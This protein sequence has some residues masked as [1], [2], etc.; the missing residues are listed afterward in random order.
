MK[1]RTYIG[2]LLLFSDAATM[3]ILAIYFRFISKNW[4][5]FQLFSLGLNIFSAFSLFAI[6]E[7]PKFLH[8]KQQYAKAKRSLKF[9]ARFN[10]RKLMDFN[11]EEEDD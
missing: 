3:A 2:T 9:I 1:Y 7:S 5:W 10:R 11:F 8:S 4:L 6:P